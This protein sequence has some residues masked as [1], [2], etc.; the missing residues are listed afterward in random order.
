MNNKEMWNFDNNT[1]MA[2]L[3]SLQHRGEIYDEFPPYLLDYINSKGLVKKY[4]LCTRILHPNKS[5]GQYR[6]TKFS[7]AAKNSLKIVI[8]LQILPS[9][10]TK[11]KQLRDPE[12]QKSLMRT[13]LRSFL[14][15]FFYGAIPAVLFCPLTQYFGKTQRPYVVLNLIIGTFVA[16]IC[17][18]S[19][20][21]A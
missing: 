1:L 6:N 18:S 21:H 9:L 19:D 10:I 14:F 8:L 20:R 3:D 12:F 11:R 16:L 5:C 17:E 7:R 15:Y 4:Q 13:A 2:S